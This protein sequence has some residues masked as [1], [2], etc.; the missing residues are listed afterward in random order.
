MAPRYESR[1]LS[2]LLSLQVEFASSQDFESD[3]LASDS[4]WPSPANMRLSLT[5]LQGDKDPD[6]E[7]EK[8]RARLNKARF[9]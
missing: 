8:E 5:P 7:R 1:I 3:L 2:F 6:E 9:E 4:V